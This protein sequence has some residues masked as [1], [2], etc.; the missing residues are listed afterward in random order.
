MQPVGSIALTVCFPSVF[1]SVFVIAGWTCVFKK[2][3]IGRQDGRE[4]FRAV[5]QFEVHKTGTDAAFDSK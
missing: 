4:T 3:C 2:T 1:R 5:A